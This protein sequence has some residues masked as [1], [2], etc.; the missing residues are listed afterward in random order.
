MK[1]IRYIHCLELFINIIKWDKKNLTENKY[2][3]F[4]GVPQ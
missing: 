4:N 1:G 2:L 3:V